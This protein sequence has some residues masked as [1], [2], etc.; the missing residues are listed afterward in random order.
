MP[1]E[2]KH[3]PTIRQADVK[4]TC[5]HKHASTSRRSIRNSTK[6]NRNLQAK[7][8]RSCSRDVSA[9]SDIECPRAD[10]HSLSSNF[11]Q[12]IMSS[13]SLQEQDSSL[14]SALMTRKSHDSQTSVFPRH[15]A[16][17][18]ACVT[19][20]LSLTAPSQAQPSPQTPV[21]LRTQLDSILDVPKAEK[22]QWA[23]HVVELSSGRV[24]YD[25]AGD[26]S[27]MPASNMKLIVMAAAIDQ[28]GPDF[29]F[30]TALAVRDTDLIVLGDGDPTIGD[31]KIAQAH[32]ESITALFHS[33]AEALKKAGIKQIP[34]NI[35]IDD[36]IFDEN[37]T[38]E[39]WPAN[40]IQ[41]WYEAPIGGLNFN[42]NCVDVV[43]EPTTPGQPAKATLVPGNTYVQ[44]VNKTITGTKQTAV[45]NRLRG[46]N[47]VQ[48]SGSVAR[49][50]NL[51]TVTVQDP[52][53]Y[54]G[55]VLRTVLATDGI[56]V[57]GKVLRQK[58]RLPNGLLPK[59]CHIV[60]VHRTPLAQ[61]LARSGKD[62]L[63]MMAECLLKRL[64][65]QQS[66]VGSWISGRSAL[67]TFMR[68]LDIR[69]DKVKVDDGSGLSRFDRVTPEAMTQVLRYIYN[70][71]PNKRELL[72]NSLS[73]AGVDGT[74]KKRLKTDDTKGRI[75]G[76]T[77]TINGVRTLAG[78]IHTQSD[79]WVA[80]AFFYNYSGKMPSP[81]AN[82][83]RACRFL[84]GW[85]DEA[86]PVHRASEQSTLKP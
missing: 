83:D 29:Q 72:K 75:Y 54:F 25:R 47:A 55:A 77:G 45:V 12:R 17:I 14:I 38:H 63:G 50:T 21:V 81:K 71:A 11:R 48:V 36:S 67:Y 60:S 64:G 30:Q 51:G 49:K 69:A 65:A 86:A 2:G 32:A 53:L 5:T 9:D 74:L 78:Y 79:E 13:Q 37:F 56:K 6:M 23:A 62:S 68:K 26:T 58:I 82:M 31:E 80:F 34:G 44:L 57:G 70:S 84:A 42:S 3:M 59:D 8:F 52:G 40:Q 73:I 41:N 10:F 66:G 35:L 76:K 16:S 15:F 1:L 46:S 20:L 22:L 7:S 18:L 28:L 24:L 43:V 39:N 4:F 61:A 19:I 85:T 27:L 33:W